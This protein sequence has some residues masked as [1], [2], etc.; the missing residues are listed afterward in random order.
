ML[1]CRRGGKMQRL[2]YAFIA[3]SLVITAIP[4]LGSDPTD[5]CG[6]E[7]EQG[8][9]NAGPLIGSSFAFCEQ[10]FF[11]SANMA[12]CHVSETCWYEWVL[13]Q[14]SYSRIRVCTSPTCFGSVCYNV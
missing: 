11:D 13:W 10:T 9:Y 14:G 12:S 7:C 8:I 3:I 5:S 6:Y 2:R 1:D 4:A